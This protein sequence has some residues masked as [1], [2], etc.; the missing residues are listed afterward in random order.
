LSFAW[1]HRVETSLQPR[2]FYA[3]EYGQNSQLGLL[4]SVV[5]SPTDAAFSLAG[6]SG[7]PTIAPVLGVLGLQSYTLNSLFIAPLVADTMTVTFTPYK[8]AHMQEGPP[9]SHSA[10]WLMYSSSLVGAPLLA[11]LTRAQPCSHEPV[12][13]H[14]MCRCGKWRAEPHQ[15]A[16]GRSAA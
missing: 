15:W 4:Q 3:V 2:T 13:H 14:A 8:G 1:K 16:A 5:A 10:C 9:A 7:L 11:V 6:V 12:N